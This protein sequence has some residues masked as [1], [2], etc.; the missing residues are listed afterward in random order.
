MS[1]ISI[2]RLDSGLYQVQIY[3]Y[4]ETNTT[5]K[6]IVSNDYLSK[7]GINEDDE[8][9]TVDLLKRSFIFLLK[10]EPKESIL[11][12]FT[13]SQIEDYFPNYPVDI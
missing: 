2:S 9:G 6:V 12:Q 1:R 5:H 8:E 4:D 11:K 13:L 3:D 7:F 10:H